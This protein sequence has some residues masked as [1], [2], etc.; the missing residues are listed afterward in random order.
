MP[1]FTPNRNYPYALPSD[2]A[3]VPTALQTLAEAIDLDLRAVE[4]QVLA[5]P[6]A[7][8]SGTTPQTVLPNVQTAMLFDFVDYD[9]DGMASLSQFPTRIQP[10]T[11]GTYW[12]YAELNC[13][14]QFAQTNDPFQDFFIRVNGVDLSRR[15]RSE[16][17]GGVSLIRTVVETASA[18]ITV[19]PGTSSISVSFQHN[20]SIPLPVTNRKLGAFRIAN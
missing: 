5:R 6:F 10:M 1:A 14:P 19:T 8:V 16:D 20:Y 2:P 3:D 9:N 18:L 12:V 13:P 11:A 15:T 4:D 17:S 7:Q